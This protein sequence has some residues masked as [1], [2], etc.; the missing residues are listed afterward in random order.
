MCIRDSAEPGA[1]VFDGGKQLTESTFLL[2]EGCLRA[3]HRGQCE[4]LSPWDARAKPVHMSHEKED[5]ELLVAG[6][7]TGVQIPL[8]PTSFV[9]SP[10]ET[11][12][13][14]LSTEDP[15]HFTSDNRGCLK[16]HLGPETPCSIMLPQQPNQDMLRSARAE[17]GALRVFL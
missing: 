14:L 1:R 16:L 8:L 11:L 7:V 13:L 5:S 10:N 4:P 9:V 2:T 15:E 6:R 17:N 3:S 12:T